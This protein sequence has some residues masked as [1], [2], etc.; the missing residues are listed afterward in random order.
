[1]IKVMQVPACC[2]LPLRERAGVRE[3]TSTTLACEGSWSG[4]TDCFPL[5]SKDPLT[6]TLSR[7]ERGQRQEQP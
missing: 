4:G 3:W 1:M 6:P 5:R 7:R 2:S